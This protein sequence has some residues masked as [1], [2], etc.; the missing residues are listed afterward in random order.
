MLCLQSSLVQY[1]QSV[2]VLLQASDFYDLPLSDDQGAI[3][4][5]LT[6]TPGAQ[7]LPTN[8]RHNVKHAWNVH[9]VQYFCPGIG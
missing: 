1:D 2:W 6:S 5:F 9:P 7:Q 8:Y 4:R 3:S